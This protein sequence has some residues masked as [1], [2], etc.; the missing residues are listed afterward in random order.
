M[1]LLCRIH[2]SYLSL[3]WTWNGINRKKEGEICIITR[4]FEQLR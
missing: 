4:R 1:L 2:A 3:S